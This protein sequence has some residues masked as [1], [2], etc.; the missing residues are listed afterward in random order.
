M[1][2]AREARA[3]AH[4][5]YSGHPVGAAIRAASGKIYGG[6]NVENAAL[7]SSQCAEAG[8]VAAMVAAGE[9]QIAAVAI[10]GPDEMSPCLPC[11]NCRQILTEFAGPDTPI[12]LAAPGDEIE[13]TTVGALLPRAFRLATTPDKQG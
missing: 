2:R 13:T 9:T 8:A 12:H 3:N 5:P 6:C 7:P 10:I 1:A 11:G 4:A